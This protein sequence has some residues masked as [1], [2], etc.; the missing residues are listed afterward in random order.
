MSAETPS[1]R[2]P[3]AEERELLAFLLSQQERGREVRIQGGTSAAGAPLS[4]AQERLW[5]LDQLAP[6]RASYNIC[7]ALRLRGRLDEAALQ[8][9]LR[10]IQVRHEALRTRFVSGEGGTPIQVVDPV[11]EAIW[12]RVDVEAVAGGQRRAELARLL[13]AEAARPFDLARGPLFRAVLFRVGDD[14]SVLALTIHHIVFDGWSFGVLHRELAA[15]YGAFAERRPSPLP[16]LRVQYGDFARWQRE[17]LRGDGLDRLLAFWR[18]QLAG[19]AD[20]LE[21][22]TDRPRPSAQSHRGARAVL[23]LSRVVSDA[24]RA[25][26]RGEKASLFMALLAALAALLH[27][28][29]GQ[30]D[31]SIGSPVANRSHP[32]TEHLIGFIANTLVL[33]TRPARHLSFRPLLAQ[34]RETC[35]SAYAHETLPFEKLVEDLN[36]QRDTSRNPLFQVLFEFQG[37]PGEELALPGLTVS[38]EAIPSGTAKFDLALS[39]QD[40]PDGVD[41][42]CHYSTDL[43]DAATVERLLGH[44][45]ALLEGAVRAPD[46]SLGD[47][48]LLTPADTAVLEATN[49]TVASYEGGGTLPELLAAAAARNP[50]A[51]AVAFGEATLSYGELEGRA[52]QLARHLQALG[53]GPDERVGL[54]L[55]RS[56]EMVV[57]LVGTL[58][59]GGVYVP[60]DPAYPSERVRY[61]LE[62]AGVRVV[63]TEERLL[64][65]VSGYAGPVVRL[66][67]DG[68]AVAARSS[69]PVEARLLPDN[70]AYVIYT[71]G[72]TGRPK[73]AMNTQR[74][75]RNRLLW[76]VSAYGM[77]PADRFLQKTPFGFDVSVWELFCPLI[78]GGLLVMARPGGHQENAHLLELMGRHGV[79]FIHFVPSMLQAFLEEDRLEAC[80][81]LKH[82]VCSGEALPASLR[83]L[84]HEK[85]G[86]ALHNLYG[87]TEAAVDVTYWRCERAAGGHTVPIG[88]PIANTR[89]HILDG[90]LR[91]LPV[92]VPG[93][94]F[95]GG[96]A[97]ARGYHARPDLT[98]EKFIPSPCGTGPGERLY[99]TGDLARV[100]PDGSVDFLGRLDHQVKVR[101]FRIE[102][103]EIEWALAGQGQ[104]REAVVMVREDVARDRRLI[105]YVV[106]RPGEAPTAAGLRAFL[107]R[108]LPEYMVPAAFVFLDKLPL[109]VNGKVDR[110]RLPPPE[111]RR[112]AA[113]ADPAPIRD[114]TE[115][116]VAAAWREVLHLPDVGPRDNFFDLGG[117]SLMMVRLRTRLSK[118]LHRDISMV[119][120]FR[121]PTIR[122]FAG[123]VRRG[124]D[125]E[126]TDPLRDAHDRALLQRQAFARRR[127][128]HE[129]TRTDE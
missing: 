15:L 128:S 3:S 55:E 2:E 103:G 47:L 64:P 113:A 93:E 48:P 25:L 18:G 60:L 31:I 94:L 70:L 109:G 119:E 44:W 83:D 49:Q 5:F 78:A 54:C 40:S 17:I 126:S 41:I 36:P 29:T 71:S 69:D 76:M 32:D 75:V 22:P 79:T 12:R 13:A 107:R 8:A 114:E 74:A 33:R 125:A 90:D 34:V 59:A 4:F 117:H 116:I 24:L 21:L 6:G 96:I 42:E 89:V 51:P 77:G 37:A 108:R 73:G 11:P 85:L 26:A 57:A 63:L 97:L 102:L 46:T 45:R 72:S 99:R 65:H 43:Y 62:D 82:V 124:E 106:S 129:R 110:R 123:Y 120:L 1:A 23:R 56:I 88:R 39:A 16:P 80:R 9:S 92:G 91:P 50:N 95:I 104:V 61:M 68:P 35:L 20:V 105:A 52:N 84:F 87:P 111:P 100:L 115:R 81:S 112:E 10:E 67:V 30:E 121:Y 58:K 14:E 98:A 19:A 28:Y 127:Q 86:C 53:V 122:S 101:G 38:M 27:R 7:R 118:A 66:D